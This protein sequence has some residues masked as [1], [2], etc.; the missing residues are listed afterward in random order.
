MGP[1]PSLRPDSPTA[2]WFDVDWEAADQRVLLPILGDGADLDRD[3]R[4]DDGEL[5]Y[6]ERRFPLSPTGRL[7]GQSPAEV[8]ERQHYRLINFRRAATDLNYRRF[9][10]VSDLAGLC[11]QDEGVFAG[12][13]PEI[14]R[15]VNDYGATAGDYE[16][17]I[18]MASPTR[19]D[20]S[21]P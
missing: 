11:V 3:L 1:S 17:T 20:I 9:F 10:A 18:P 4:I 12:T 2:S 6:F 19:G 14:L 15:W 8:H 13:H 21:M 7:R 16:S 5:V